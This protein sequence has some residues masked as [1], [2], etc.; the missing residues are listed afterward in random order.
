MSR[1]N[2]ALNFASD[3]ANRVVITDASILRPDAT[4]IFS[5]CNWFYLFSTNNNLLPRFVEKGAHYTCIMGDQTVGTVH[6]RVALEVQATGTVV[7]YWGSTK[8]QPNRWYHIATTFNDG[9]CQHYLNGVKESMVV[10]NNALP[11]QSPLETSAGSD[12]KIGN[13]SA[14]TRNPNGYICNVTQHNVALTQEEVITIMNG[15]NVSRGLVGK[16]N[17]DEGTGATVADSSGNGNN[18]TIT[19]AVWETFVNTRNS[20]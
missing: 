16:W 19:G 4:N 10:I 18:G 17:V 1:S 9:E 13:S 14:N 5:W 3:A 20:V 8:I 2:K 6:N 12:L 15:G 11:Y 7:E